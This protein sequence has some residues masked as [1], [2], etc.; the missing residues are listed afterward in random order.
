M[1]HNPATWAR[2][3][4]FGMDVSKPGVELHHYICA[5]YYS[6]TETGF[7]EMIRPRMHVWVCMSYAYAPGVSSDRR[8]TAYEPM[9]I[10]HIECTA[11]GLGIQ[12]FGRAMLNWPRLHR[13]K[14]S[15]KAPAA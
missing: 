7:G 15:H 6:C 3:I 5:G 12:I 8:A 9:L 14:G 11:D 4:A 13:Y 2:R 1:P 10:T